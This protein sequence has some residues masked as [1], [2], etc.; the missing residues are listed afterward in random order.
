MVYFVT[1]CIPN[2]IA[3]DAGPFSNTDDVFFR[4]EAKHFTWFLNKFWF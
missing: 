2:S 4:F 3:D 1:E